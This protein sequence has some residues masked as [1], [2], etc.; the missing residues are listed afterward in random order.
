MPV[1]ARKVTLWTASRYTLEA[2][3]GLAAWFGGYHL[4]EMVVTVHLETIAQIY[5]LLTV[6]L[7]MSFCGLRVYQTIRKER[8]ANISEALHRTQHA[9]RNVNTMIR[10]RR[11]SADASEDE[12]KDFCESARSGFEDILSQVQMI[13]TQLTSTHCRTS[14]KL[15]YNIG[16]NYF[17]YTLARD[18][19]TSQKLYEMDEWRIKSDHDSLTKNKQ[20]SRI[21]ADDNE[22]WHY[23]SADLSADPDFTSTS[24]EA[25]DREWSVKSPN[26][27]RTWLFGRRDRWSLPYIS[28]IACI[29]RQGPDRACRVNK[30]IALGF[31]TVDSESRRVF[32]ER[33]DVPI[34]FSVADALFHPLA[35]YLEV[36]NRLQPGSAL[37]RPEQT[38]RNVVV[39]T[40]GA[41][42]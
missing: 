29:I 23:I 7:F 18:K 14:I 42:K 19:G 20:F 13:F 2:L 33:W 15:I 17:F 4:L 16:G 31:L 41:S 32:E 11:P 10:I 12:I 40:E 9:I 26:G 38:G 27:I 35:A 24:F 34:L 21:F 25:Y 3:A 22:N 30:Q 8:Y 5:T 39:R 1:S 6:S 28:T 37:V 36:Q